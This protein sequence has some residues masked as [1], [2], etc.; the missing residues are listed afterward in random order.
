MT[1]NQGPQPE[2]LFEQN[3]V[4]YI[5]PNPTNE[6]VNHEDLVVYVKLIAKSK[7]RSILT[8]TE[9]ETIIIEKE[10][11]NVKE[12]TNFTYT[13]GKNYIDTE[14]T[15]IGGGPSPLGTDLGGFGITNIN[16]DFK[17]SFMPQ[18]II[19]F[20]DVRGAALFE[21][22]PCSPYSMFFHLPYPVFELTVKGYY[23]K[24][25]TYSLA[26][27]KFN[28][29]F[30]AETGNFESK[31]EFVGYTYAFLADIPIGY[32]LAA[33][34]MEDGPQV[35]AEK[36]TKI[37]SKPE[38]TNSPY[39]LNPDR[40][41][42]IFDMIVKAKKLETQ[43]PQLKN[44]TEVQD[45]AKLS[46]VRKSL[47]KLKEEVLDYAREIGQIVKQKRPDGG[48][49][50]NPEVEN[51][52][53]STVYYI[54]IDKT[55]T[56]SSTVNKI[57]KVNKIFVS[58][59]LEQSG[60]NAGNISVSLS[61]TK[62][63][64]EVA[65]ISDPPVVTFD[66]FQEG[67]S[68]FFGTP[69]IANRDYPDYDEYYID[70]GPILKPI[71]EA[72]KKVN[73]QY[74]GKR[75][76]VQ[77]KL[78]E[79]VLEILEFWPS[80]R[81]VFA[82][83]LSNTEVFLELMARTSK[84][85]E[86]YHTNV[87]INEGLQG[88]NRNVIDINP[89]TGADGGDKKN[90]T[91]PWPT[92]YET[93]QKTVDTE[94]DSGE[95]ETY[96]GENENFVAWPEVNFCEDFIQ[97]LTKLRKD[98][99][100]LEIEDTD[101][102][103]GFDNYAPI[104]AF[105][106]HM[107]DNQKAPNRWFTSDEGIEGLT[108][109]M[110][111]IYNVMGEN[112]FIL[113]DYSMINTLSLWKSQLGF[114]NG[115]GWEPLSNN[116]G[117]SNGYSNTSING[118]DSFNQGPQRFTDNPIVN[119]NIDTQNL[120]R[121]GG[122]GFTG[123]KDHTVTEFKGTFGE[124]K[125]NFP[126][127]VNPT[128]KAKIRHWGRIDAINL[129]Q[130]LSSDGANETLRFI[131]QNLN[132]DGQITSETLKNLIKKALIKKYKD[133]FKEETFSDWA[134]SAS[135]AINN[136]VAKPN[137]ITKQNLWDEHF[138]YVKSKPVLTLKGPI[139]LNH[140]EII[141]GKIEAN[142]WNN[143]FQ[144]VRL[145][146]DV[147]ISSR[148]I[149][150]SS[151]EVVPRIDELFRAEYNNTTA[152]GDNVETS[153]GGGDTSIT[154]GSIFNKPVWDDK[155]KGYSVYFKHA[156]F[157][158]GAIKE[159]GQG[160]ELEIDKHVGMLKMG[161]KDFR[162]NFYHTYE[163]ADNLKNDSGIIWDLGSSRTIIT[164]DKSAVKKTGYNMGNST[165][166]MTSDF[167][168]AQA[169]IGMGAADAFVQTP[170]WTTNYPPYKCPMHATYTWITN[171]EIVLMESTSSKP[172]TVKNPPRGTGDPKNDD[173][174]T[175]GFRNFATWWGANS[176]YKTPQD[177]SGK[178][179]YLPLA[180]L[181][182]M[183]F[184]YEPNSYNNELA[185]KN[186]TGHHIPFDGNVFTA[187]GAF[188]NFTNQ[189]IVVE[190]PK[191][192]LLLLGA[193]L[194]RAK[195]GFLLDTD[196]DSNLLTKTHQYKGWNHAEQ[197]RNLFDSP[198]AVS[199][200]LGDPVWFFHTST[201]KP[202]QRYGTIPTIRG[203]NDNND[204]YMSYVRRYLGFDDSG[205]DRWTDSGGSG[206]FRI[207]EVYDQFQG[208]VLDT[209][210][211]FVSQETE[212]GANLPNKGGRTIGSCL[213]ASYST[214]GYP[215]ELCY[216]IKSPVF[217]NRGWTKSQA[218]NLSLLQPVDIDKNRFNNPLSA[219]SFRT[220]LN[221]DKG[222]FD[223]CRQDQMPFII[224]QE[225]DDKFNNMNY[226]HTLVITDLSE[227]R[228]PWKPDGLH[229]TVVL[230]AEKKYGYESSSPNRV[231]NRYINLKEKVKELMFLPTD[232][233]IQL[234]D[235]FETWAIDEAVGDETKDRWCGILD[236]LNFDPKDGLIL[237]KD[238]VSWT[239]WKKMDFNKT[240]FQY[241]L[242]GFIQKSWTTA[243]SAGKVSTDSVLAGGG[244][245]GGYFN[246]NQMSSNLWYLAYAGDDNFGRTYTYAATKPTSTS[247]SSSG[248][249]TSSN[250][251]SKHGNCFKS[252]DLVEMFNGE[253]KV[254]K[255]VEVGD[256]VKSI[257]NNKVVKGIV[258]KKLVHPINNVVEV[259]KINGITAEPN[260]PT[261]FKGKWVPIKELGS[262]T[263]EF[264]DNWYNLEIDGNTNNSEPNY[265]IGNLIVSGV[266]DNI[267]L[268]KLYNRQGIF[269]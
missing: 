235:Y 111:C 93:I 234:I 175:N 128:T 56:Q 63:T 7:G 244:E 108:E 269:K 196:Y 5:D 264:I 268:N 51:N 147:E 210:T 262:I 261:Y 265:I 237:G 52:G 39:G 215:G 28:T 87:D 17:S 16:I 88:S 225:P 150:I 260:H 188:S 195:E 90:F 22:G 77:K 104:T 124:G 15:N 121:Y 40:P 169:Q 112:A 36:W 107:F 194:W 240:Q 34:Y 144:G 105:E 246:H 143:P 76:E 155:N 84:E 113:G 249:W 214:L 109:V 114:T 223:Q 245:G 136:G 44:T 62:A 80:I 252:T 153:A 54:R 201:S 106:T 13:E 193:I 132:P 267:K 208:N 228:E 45:V 117:N 185:A 41:I 220:G 187:Q 30:N 254:I 12:N 91:Y 11:K 131:K 118:V 37:T 96:P 145:A 186:K 159:Q 138:D 33:N 212:G 222:L 115:Y 43:L 27:T 202:L 216:E 199:N 25:V 157:T 184:G 122:A 123:L 247:T 67:A 168:S 189:H 32:I 248:A 35:L 70:I 241:G 204:V 167:I 60:F 99:Q 125:Y 66:M 203:D 64:Y 69:I 257:R 31:G 82:I 78:N 50:K 94:G 116:Q 174:L 9:D 8:N 100:V 142:P 177:E 102:K 3:G 46:K 213:G 250:G 21:Q 263:T 191:S 164:N 251:V 127:K 89:D 236:P 229:V 1:L 224:Q 58:T 20:V 158:K 198:T 173:T 207:S 200:D 233:K 259:I 171:N 134:N 231:P 140:S 79:K 226:P 160:K 53:I 239:D 55:A 103:P 266:G 232:F 197:S 141:D 221:I 166:R 165:A 61:N 154:W 98:L 6:I 192:W 181:A 209:Y 243:I 238:G 120:G 206:I 242:D 68:G 182:V 59:D 139:E 211:F 227:T 71:D 156:E 230:D 65:G 101:N 47:V 42:T 151:T 49:R 119:E 258:T 18:I 137:L 81:N 176:Y 162:Y 19:D 170:L 73:T 110:E 180:Y 172:L 85:A 72:L 255:N 183:S 256:G 4:R 178:K 190:P 10:L 135:A 133:N 38:F 2:I 217:L 149:S 163:E 126:T 23:G 86:E 146:T 219:D 75:K 57:N 48:I 14:W 74:K 92:Y 161:I 130:T 97:A 253:M 95:K 129:L 179:Y 205:V 83:L 26:L 24:P 152:E 29:K 148:D 218:W